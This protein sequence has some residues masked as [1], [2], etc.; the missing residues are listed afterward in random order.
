LEVL[1]E[2]E[3]CLGGHIPIQ[4]FFDLIVGTRFGNPRFPAV[5][6]TL[7]QEVS[8]GGIIAMGLGVENW[9]VETCIAHF[10]KLADKAF[11]PRLPGTRFGRRYKTKPFEK[12]LQEAFKDECLFGG[13]HEE[14][15]SYYTKVAITA[16]T[17]TGEK[18]VIF[19]N[20]NRQMETQRS[21]SQSFPVMLRILTI[22]S[23]KLFSDQA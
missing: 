23:G 15:S 1:R 2:I 7:M 13:L 4:S 17:D 19:T 5:S 20:Y 3:E 18:P 8:T 6:L 21:C 12:A 10:M 14:A 16:T 22:L 11:T 9:R